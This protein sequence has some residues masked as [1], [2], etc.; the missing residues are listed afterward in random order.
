M[1]FGLSFIGFSAT[2]VS[3]SGQVPATAP[4]AEVAPTT[5]AGPSVIVQPA[6]GALKQTLIAVHLEKWKMSKAVRDVTVGNINS[7]GRDVD[8]TL[9]S[10]LATADAAPNSVAG[11]LPVS[12]NMA[13]L[14]DVLLRVTVVAEVSAPKDQADALEQAMVNLEGTR[15]TF[16]D[17]VQGAAV[18][19]D[20]QVSDL[21]KTLAS[22]PAV[23]VA[24]P[25]PVPA[26]V[27]PVTHPKRK[28]KPAAKPATKPS[29]PPA[30][31]AAKAPG[32]P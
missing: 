17:Q 28:K 11:M 16:D 3:A 32:T 6:I 22:R 14:Y 23:V 13:A 27:A 18:L 4:T 12:R 26:V 24:P 9:P 20:Q 5:Q 8:S 2:V 15:H 7:I 10:L 29:S 31:P 1:I 19:R 25:A 30:A 21:R